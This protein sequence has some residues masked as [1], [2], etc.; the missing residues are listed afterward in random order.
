MSEGPYDYAR[1]RI[2][3]LDKPYPISEREWLDAPTDSE[4]RE[5]A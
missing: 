5:E 2:D 1:E 3:A 4:L